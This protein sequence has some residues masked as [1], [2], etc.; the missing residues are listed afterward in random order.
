MPKKPKH[1]N[2]SVAG[3]SFENDNGSSRQ[4]IISKYCRVGD[5]VKLISEPDNKYDKNAIMV[6]LLNG[7][8]IG[9]L[10]STFAYMANLKSDNLAAFIEDIDYVDS[11]ERII[12]V[13]LSIFEWDDSVNINEVKE[14]IESKRNLVIKPSLL[15]TTVKSLVSI[16]IWVGSKTIAITPVVFRKTLSFSKLSYDFSKKIAAKAWDKFI[17]SGHS[18][19]Q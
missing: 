10:K 19:N 11:H 2:T 13:I 6:Y 18:S 14:L 16:P 9:Y 12:Y 1:F 17:S 7:Q 3:V 8:Q 5:Y 4:R 15:E